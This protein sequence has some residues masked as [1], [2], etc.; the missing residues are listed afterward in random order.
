MISMKALTNAN[1]LKKE[2]TRLLNSYTNYSWLTAWAGKPFELTDILERNI[3]KIDKIVVGLH[4]YQTHPDFIKKFINIKNVRF[5]KQTEGT[6]H[7]KLYL[8]ENSNDDWELIT[9]SSNFTNSAFSINTETNILITSKS[10]DNVNLLN[11]IKEQIEFSWSIANGFSINELD[12]Y[13]KIFLN[14]ERKINSL[15]ST[16][17]GQKEK[18]KPVYTVPVITMN[19]NEYVEKV[20]ND[21][22]HSVNERLR[23]LERSNKY[24]NKYINFEKM[25]AEIRKA[26]AGTYISITEMDDWFY[27]G[28]MQ[29]AGK[30]KNRILEND[31]NISIALDQIPLQGQITKIHFEEYLRYFLKSSDVQPIATATRLLALKRPDI[32]LCLDSKNRSKLCKA[33]EIQYSGMTLEKYWDEIIE[34]IFDSEWWINPKPRNEFEQK[35]RNNRS[36]MLDSLYYTK[37]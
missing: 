29:G 7:P 18:N 11:K 24:Y 5:I 35:L 20:V 3:N 36:A 34:R 1:D 31:K 32:F 4:F 15:S 23:I 33:F 9:G 2:F 14:Q 12:E 13:R 37:D 30:F 27:F 8:F 26:I 28:S 16:Y 10:G 25:P 6:F 22:Y 21:Q 17:G 19:W